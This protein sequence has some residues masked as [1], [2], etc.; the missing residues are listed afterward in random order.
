M[1]A[2]FFFDC[3]VN[4]AKRIVCKM[5]CMTATSFSTV[6][7][8]FIYVS[9]PAQKC[10]SRRLSWV[11]SFAFVYSH[12]FRPK[13]SSSLRFFFFSTHIAFL[14][15]SLYA[16]TLWIYGWY[17]RAQVHARFTSITVLCERNGRSQSWS[18]HYLFDPNEFIAC[19]ISQTLP[20]INGT[21]KTTYTQNFILLFFLPLL[22]FSPLTNSFSLNNEI[23]GKMEKQ[24]E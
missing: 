14:F 5:L 3:S 6:H 10:C 22:C 9:T 1:C 13:F 23:C 8:V 16:F 24:R 20:P 17:S 7:H 12:F 18:T 15:T 21:F 4:V 19:I 2:P 11:C